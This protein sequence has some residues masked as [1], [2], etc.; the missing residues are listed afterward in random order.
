M[1]TAYDQIGGQ[2]RGLFERLRVQIKTGLDPTLAVDT[3]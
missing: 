3:P 2:L 1:P